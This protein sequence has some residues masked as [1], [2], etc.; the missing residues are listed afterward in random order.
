VPV[1]EI[2]FGIPLEELARLDIVVANAGVE[3]VGQSDLDFT[4]ADFQRSVRHQY[5][6]RLLHASESCEACRPLFTPSRSVHD[7][8]NLLRRQASPA[9]ES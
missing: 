5:Q 1:L 9:R 2:T 4:Q 3:L 8:V 7:N 6:G